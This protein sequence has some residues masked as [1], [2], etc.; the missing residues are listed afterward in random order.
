MSRD[1]FDP[2]GLRPRRL[3]P[4]SIF[5]DAVRGEG[6]AR[7]SAE[8]IATLMARGLVGRRIEIERTPAVAAT[9][10]RIDEVTPATALAALPTPRGEVPVWRRFRGRLVGVTIGDHRI[11]SVHVDASDVRLLAAGGRLR[12]TRV[13]L[14][15]STEVREIDRW[16]AALTGNVRLRLHRGR[17]E[18][19][20]RRLVRWAWVE[21]DVVAFGGRVRVTPRVLWLGNRAVPLPARLRRP[22]EREVGWLPRELEVTEVRLEGDRLLATGHV[23]GI[24]APVDLPRLLAEIGSGNART[25]LRIASGGSVG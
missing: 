17:V 21:V 19:S 18:L 23:E 13:E 11:G 7:Q 12:A 16:F 24:G 9:V 20:D 8:R 14:A 1:W 22:I 6:V 5:A 4:I 25:V 3:D 2:L 15:S 10:E